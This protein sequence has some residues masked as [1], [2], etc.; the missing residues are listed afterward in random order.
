MFWFALPMQW[1]KI[2][3][4]IWKAL[5]FSKYTDC[6]GPGEFSAVGNNTAIRTERSK[7][8]IQLLQLE[9]WETIL[10][11]EQKEFRS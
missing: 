10:P 9:Q 8:L 4:Y 5:I 2:Y 11:S 1:L 6:K 3:F 7:Q